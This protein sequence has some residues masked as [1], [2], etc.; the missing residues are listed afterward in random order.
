MK[1]LSQQLS[2]LSAQAKKV[3]DRV[4][5]AQS[6]T[7]D[8]LEEQR[9]KAHQEAHAALERVKDKVNQASEGTKS[10][11]A[12]LKSKIDTDF[13]RMRENAD[14]REQKFEAW[15]AGNYADDKAADAQATIE[16][17]VA[18]IKLAEVATLDAVDAR[19]RAEIK[20]DE[21]Q[22]IQA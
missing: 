20:A 8:R 11:F 7:K 6:E 4:A 19:T 3:E 22:P 9:A 21:A 2:E 18:A 12:E 17:A 13:Q 1:P 14:A 15:Q 5:Q 16:Y 10:H